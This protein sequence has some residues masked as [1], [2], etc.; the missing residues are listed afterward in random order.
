MIEAVEPSHEIEV[1]TASP[2]GPLG[3]AVNRGHTCSFA[4][5]G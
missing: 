1:S 2:N 5:M 3:D 4:V